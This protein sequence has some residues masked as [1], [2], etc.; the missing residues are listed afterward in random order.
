[1]QKKGNHSGA[2]YCMYLDTGVEV[3]MSQSHTEGHKVF[4]HNVGTLLEFVRLSGAD[5]KNKGLLG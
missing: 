2:M 4:A 1:M 5:I 3:P